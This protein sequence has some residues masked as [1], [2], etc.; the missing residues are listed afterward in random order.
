MREFIGVF[1]AFLDIQ[2]VFV[3]EFYEVIYALEEPQQLALTN[4]WLECDSVLVC[5]AFTIR[6]N[7]P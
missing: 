5:V 6:T 4:I 1:Y 3:A 7:V 2:T